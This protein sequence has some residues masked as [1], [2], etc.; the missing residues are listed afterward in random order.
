MNSRTH[1]IATL[2]LLLAS[3]GLIACEE[4]APEAPPVPTPVA[5]PRPPPSDAL[6]EAMRAREE[7]EAFALTPFGTPSRMTLHE[8]ER[9]SFSE[10]LHPGFCYKLL[11]E[12]EAGIT[13]VDAYLFDINSVLMQQDA[14]EGGDLALGSDRPICIQEPSMVRTELRVVHGQ[15]ALLAQWYVNQ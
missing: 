2:A 5:P 11:V 1:A 7:T 6:E 4:P 9:Q 3:Q 12:S 10:V 8:G 15:G 14:R 13:D